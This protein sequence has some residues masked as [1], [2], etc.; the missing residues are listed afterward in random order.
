MSQGVGQDDL[1]EFGWPGCLHARPTSALSDVS[2]L[3][4]RWR[5]RPSSHVFSSEWPLR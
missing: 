3:E 5:L 1:F 2:A 4:S